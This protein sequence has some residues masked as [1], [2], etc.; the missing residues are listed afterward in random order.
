MESKST[1][2]TSSCI[3]YIAF[4]H[5]HQ[6]SS[7]RS[8]EPSKC[9]FRFIL[10]YT[11]SPSSC[12]LSFDRSSAISQSPPFPVL[13]PRFFVLPPPTI[14]RDDAGMTRW[15]VFSLCSEYIMLYTLHLHSVY[16]AKEICS[17]MR[18]YSLRV[19]HVCESSSRDLSGS[20]MYAISDYE[21]RLH[22]L[23]CS[24]FGYALPKVCEHA[25]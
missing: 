21:S 23:L 18:S 13:D 16:F 3:D 12:S 9:P 4:Q 24:G 1:R 5:G 2:Q 22:A 17:M 20:L 7:D 6:S 8:G 15:V 11:V 10:R 19:T 25:C 14:P